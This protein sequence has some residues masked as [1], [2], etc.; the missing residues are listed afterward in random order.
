M[1]DAQRPPSLLD[2]LRG[3]GTSGA[4][5][6][7]IMDAIKRRDRVVGA[8]TRLSD[9]VAEFDGDLS[10]CGERLDELWSAVDRYKV[11]EANA[12]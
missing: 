3:F 2:R 9:C 6:G 10:F 1:G 11:E 7:E 5:S 12:E 4:T 8:A